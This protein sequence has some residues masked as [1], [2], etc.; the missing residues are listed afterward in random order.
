M[1]FGEIS[2][3]EQ[4]VLKRFNITKFPTLL[5]YQTHEND[6]KLDDPKV[7]IYQ[8]KIQVAEIYKFI[9][10]YSLPYKT[11]IYFKTKEELLNRE[12]AEIRRIN[13]ENFKDFFSNN[14][15]KKLMVSFSDSG[16]FP[17]DLNAF[18]KLTG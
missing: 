5:V 9:E 16:E 7:N 1:L 17:K 12:K 2:H 10:K 13:N 4:S 8:G 14:Y 6:I 15:N 11:Y 3:S 18:S